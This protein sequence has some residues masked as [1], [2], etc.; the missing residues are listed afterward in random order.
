MKLTDTE[1]GLL[2]QLT[3]IKESGLDLNDCKGLT[4]KEIL[5]RF[6]EEELKKI[7]KKKSC[8]AA[9]SGKE[10]ADIIRTIKKSERLTELKLTDTM[11]QG[12]G[13][14]LAACFID[15]KEPKKAIV[16]FKGTTGKGEW[17]DNASGFN[18]S[19][20]A[21][22]IDAL[23]YINSLKYTDITVTGHSKGGNK[24]MYV[25]ITSEKVSRCVAFDGQG[26]SQEFLDKYWAEINQRGN[27]ITSYSLKSDFVHILM[28]PIPTANN[29]YCRGYGVDGTAEL[30]APNSFF[31]LDPFGNILLDKNGNPI[32]TLTSEDKGI[33]Y[34][35]DF[36][37]FVLNTA[38]DKDK[39]VITNFL[40]E[41]LG[42][43]FDGNLDEGD[44]KEE[45]LNIIG[46]NCD[47]VAK[48]LAYFSKYIQTRG[49]SK[50]D[51]KKIM[52]SLKI[53]D[54]LLDFIGKKIHISGDILEEKLEKFIEVN[55]M[56]PRGSLE[57]LVEEIVSCLIKGILKVGDLAILL[58]KLGII[59]STEAFTE[60]F[61]NTYNSINVSGKESY[62]NAQ[63]KQGKKYNYSQKVY[64]AVI[65]VMKRIDS[66]SN[67]IFSEWNNYS[68]EEW[69]SELGVSVALKG[70]KK[71]FDSII[72]VDSKCK[73]QI[74]R[75]FSEVSKIDKE[76]AK[77]IADII[78]SA[79]KEADKIAIISAGTKIVKI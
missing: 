53:Y 33:A 29:K 17:A 78:I 10:V 9:M 36:T 64:N 45:I 74:D 79:D 31:V 40:E 16:A 26:F 50:N 51:V 55:F 5:E 8:D 76:Y 21:C 68:S 44:K 27:K 73:K 52:R 66:E 41:L 2:E 59:D 69:Y 6:T 28:F 62:A 19:D 70:L 7:E 3:Y 4:I 65:D 32:F 34:L 61:M 23:N 25:A 57:F 37:S 14:C 43:I 38:T 75:V 18:K 22:Q 77:K 49:L 71:Y 20:T 15:D 67:M 58:C 72:S 35:H 47:G 54:L 56:L 60:E 42:T 24:A 39:I 63:V 46:N 13:A 1:L 30:H 12:G 11:K 48:V